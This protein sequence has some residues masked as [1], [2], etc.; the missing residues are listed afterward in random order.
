MGAARGGSRCSPGLR[1]AATGSAPDS[2]D[3][4]HHVELTRPGALRMGAACGGSRC[5]LGL[6]PA[7]T[8]LVRN[9]T[10]ERGSGR[11]WRPSRD[12]PST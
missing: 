2:G 11:L 7:A 6:R 4:L 8:V 10:I 12:S 1:P 3:Y 5:S 9:E